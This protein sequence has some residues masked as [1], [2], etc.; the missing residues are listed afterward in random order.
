MLNLKDIDDLMDIVEELVDHKGNQCELVRREKHILNRLN[1]HR[2]HIVDE[3][4]R[5]EGNDFDTMR[6]R[7]YLGLDGE[8]S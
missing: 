7:T 8:K 1:N 2:A 5:L 3:I 6:H 4:Q